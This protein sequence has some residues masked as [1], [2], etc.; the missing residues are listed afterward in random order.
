M[1]GH[2]TAKDSVAVG[3]RDTLDQ[4]F[5]DYLSVKG[6]NLDYR[7]KKA[8]IDFLR[9][10]PEIL[11]ATMKK[12]HISQ[13]FVEAG[14]IDEETGMVPVFDKLIGTCKRWVS[15]LKEI[16]VPKSV[17]NHCKSQFQCLMAIQMREGQITYSDIREVE[18]P[19]G[20]YPC[21]H[22]ILLYDI[23]NCL[24]TYIN[25]V[26]VS[27]IN[28]DGSKVEKDRPSGADSE[29]KQSAKTINAKAQQQKRVEQ[30][31]MK[32]ALKFTEDT[33]TRNAII[34]IIDRNRA[35]ENKIKSAI[36][37][38]IGLDDVTAA[39]LN[40]AKVATFLACNAKELTD[41]THVRKFNDATFHKSKLTGADGKLN[42]TVT[43]TQT[44]KSIEQNCSKESP[45][46]VWLAWKL[47]SQPIVLEMPPE[48]FLIA[49]SS[50]V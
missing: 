28:P 10:L 34:N 6:L 17:K 46:L 48:P 36:V 47:R 8:L 24:T 43:R 20:T 7:K 19:V 1:Q 40:D 50:R 27:D 23:I 14:M 9:C 29:H 4:F 35:V 25:A 11:E 2:T 21:L 30:R 5:S 39:L 12:K 42:R 49:D 44:A 16:G 3:L 32:M 41:F 13:S 26:T 15:S 37:T 18:I 38:A 45:C 22:F 31:R 33:K